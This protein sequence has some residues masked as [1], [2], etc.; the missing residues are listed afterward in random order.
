MSSLFDMISSF[1]ALLMSAAFLHFGAGAEEAAKV[2][3]PVATAQKTT[4]QSAAS[5]SGAAADW[6][7]RPANQPAQEAT[8]PAKVIRQAP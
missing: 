8:P 7:S 5:L 4:E 6:Q 1:I 3:P 2:E